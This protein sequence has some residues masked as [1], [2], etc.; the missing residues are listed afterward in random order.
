MMNKWTYIRV[1]LIVISVIT[2]LWQGPTS[3]H[4][5]PPIDSTA[6]I[7]AILFGIFGLQFVLAIQAVNKRSATTWKTASWVENPFTLK[8]PVQ[9]FHFGG[10]LFVVSSLVS[11]ALTWFQKPEYILDSL[12]PFCFGLGILGGVHLSTVIFRR[13]FE[14][15]EKG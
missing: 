9:F 5:S 3:S 10:W 11:V 6:L 4:A 14:P 1:A 8:Q 12:M 2:I 7:I 13:K 15:V